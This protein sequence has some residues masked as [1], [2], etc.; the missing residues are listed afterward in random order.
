V[1]WFTRILL[2]GVLSRRYLHS[3]RDGYTQQK[4]ATCGIRN[5]INTSCPTLWKMAGRRT[6]VNERPPAKNVLLMLTDYRKDEEADR[7]LVACLA[8]QYET[9]YFW[10]QGQMD[11]SYLSS[12]LPPTA[13]KLVVLD[14]TLGALDDCLAATPDLDYV[15]TRLHGGIRCLHAGKRSLILEVDNRATEIAKETGLPSLPRSDVANI[16]KWVKVG[17]KSEIWVDEKPIQKWRQ[18]FA[19]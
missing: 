16:E 18:Q 7:L 12:L 8:A 2:K 3:V 4:L 5:V 10:P 13:V 17:W 14:R 11:L 1:T 6:T 19:N 15:G 9:I